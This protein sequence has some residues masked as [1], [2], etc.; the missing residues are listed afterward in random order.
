MSNETDEI[1]DPEL[2]QGFLEE[3]TENLEKLDN[4]FVGLEKNPEDKEIID[5]IFRQL[6]TIKGNSGFFGFSKL[7][8][9]AHK[10]ESVLSEIRK[11]KLKISEEIIT[12]LLECTDGIRNIVGHISEDMTEGPKNYDALEQTLVR[13]QQ[14]A[15]RE[16][17]PL[18]GAAEAAAPNPTPQAADT[19]LEQPATPAATQP[20]RALPAP[21][22]KKQGT[23]RLDTTIR[24]N[25]NLV[26]NL[27]NQVGE[28]VLARNQILQHLTA[29][30]VQSAEKAGTNL[31]LITTQLQ[32]NIM[33]TRLQP[34]GI[35]FNKFPRI[36]RDME[37]A[38]G[39]RIDLTIEGESTEVDKTL[40]EAI[41]DPLTHIIRNAVDHGIESPQVR[42]Q[43]GKPAHG[44][45]ALKAY[46]EG[47]Q[48]IVEVSDDGAGINANKV[49]EKAIQNSLITR[50]D[51]PNMKEP[52]IL[53]LI[54]E[55]GFST[56]AQVTNISGRGVGMDVVK[57]NIEKVRGVIDIET[58]EGAGTIFRL[59]IPLT[60]AIIPA[61]IVAVGQERFAIPQVNLIE[62]MYFE[63]DEIDENIQ[64][65][66]GAAFIFHRGEVI[67]VVE[68]GAL[69]KLPP[70][71]EPPNAEEK[72]MYIVIVKTGTGVF[73]LAVD[74]PI[75][76]EEIVVK[77]L[78]S[79][80]K[81]LGC[82]AG[83]TIMGDGRVVLILDVPGIARMLRLRDHSA[84]AAHEPAPE[85]EDHL[86][87][88][89]SLGTEDLFALPVVLITRI[90]EF[91][92]SSL[93]S[94]G[95]KQA[96]LYGD[97]LLPLI[98]LRD[99][100]PVARTDLGELVTVLVLEF[101]GRYIGLMVKEVIDSIEY[102]GT[103]DDTT[104]TAPGVLGSIIVQR[105]GVLLLDA[106]GLV[107]MAEPGWFSSARDKLSKVDSDQ[108]LRILLVE[109]S[110]F[111]LNLEKGYLEG[112][113]FEVVTATD[114]HDGLSII[115]QDSAFDLVVTD[116]EMPR[117]DGLSMCRAIR[118][119]LQLR[120][121]PIMAIT[122]LTSLEVR[123]K[124]EEIGINDFQ[125]KVN[126]ENIISSA[127]R[128]ATGH[129]ASS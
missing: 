33:K 43:K 26:E 38:T 77:P 113:G 125:V 110:P 107:D 48:V 24:V 88:V 41:G 73:G 100:L 78:I 47:G 127:K 3:A 32:E 101:G 67:P 99:H 124:A 16:D 129:G 54:F 31:D 5:G 15:K 126:R 29:N 65:I 37:K 108:R 35:V 40:I 49:L 59:Q 118:N 4:D 123:N 62:L 104:F 58:E 18:G 34:I 82:F 46:H 103:V 85:Q 57:T 75:D 19:P 52:E 112:A 64:E 13:L 27:I 72:S 105:K 128:L 79:H 21:S 98:D 119:E 90:E 84:V 69:F 96:V 11:D 115:R 39:K 63:G 86:F 20:D 95:D 14:S 1:L 17:S 55:P 114:G 2:V 116:I 81:Q 30:D 120:D 121:L 23:K 91:P 45:I 122:S 92:V 68:L 42:A 10:G 70:K 109:D 53:S 51:A 28:L 102:V 50:A 71:P 6:H 8:S 83:A 117:M 80:I 60:L 111:F 66:K 44:T 7:E 87:L 61:L 89:F 97:K 93:M 74:R 22:A 56:A 25:L 106:F 12:A 94:V 36:V 76:S 9:L